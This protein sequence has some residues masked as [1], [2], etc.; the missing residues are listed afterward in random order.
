[1]ALSRTP[2]PEGIRQESEAIDPGT[3][4]RLLSPTPGPI[5]LWV[6]PKGVTAS[7]QTAPRQLGITVHQASQIS[8][9]DWVK[10]INDSNDVP[11]YFKEQ[12]KSKDDL[13]YVTNAKKFRYPTN[14][15][16]KDWLS[17]WLSAFMVADWA[18]TTGSLDISIK[19]GDAGGSS[20]SCTIPTYR[21]GRPLMV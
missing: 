2:G 14:V 4:A 10:K 7:P 5:G 3:L 20:R 17:D 1:M 9:Q 15:I 18:M 21:A 16:P 11:D 12:I 13:I 19:K 6:K 8:A